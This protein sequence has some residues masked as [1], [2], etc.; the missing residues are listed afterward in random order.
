MK[1]AKKKNQCY[2]RVHDGLLVHGGLLED[3][4]EEKRLE[5]VLG[6]WVGFGW[7]EE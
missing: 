2:G 1:G 3:F 7:V 5:L 4:M 6:T